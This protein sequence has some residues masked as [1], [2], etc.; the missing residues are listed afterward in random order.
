MSQYESV[1]AQEQQ[2]NRDYLSGMLA[3]V[4]IGGAVEVYRT[5]D[6]TFA[7]LGFLSPSGKEDR[8]AYVDARATQN[9]LVDARDG[10]KD[11]KPFEKLVN[12]IV[13]KPELQKDV[14][15][16]TDGK[17]A[18]NSWLTPEQSVASPLTGILGLF[19]VG[20]GATGIAVRRFTRR[21]AKR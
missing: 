4:T 16:L 1:A 15:T 8:E 20:V 11:G 21:Q 13:S 12:G 19:A 3:I 7:A 2:L 10:Q 17:L 6:E 18:D 14:V 9:T 5:H